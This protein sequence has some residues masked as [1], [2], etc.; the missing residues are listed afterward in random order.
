M[1]D[2]YL[3]PSYPSGVFILATRKSMLMLNSQQQSIGK[4]AVKLGFTCNSENLGFCLSTRLPCSSLT[5][6]LSENQ[7]QCFK[8]RQALTACLLFP[9]SV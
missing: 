3:N 5:S 4:Q 9:L 8:I 7:T 6:S 2:L 1:G